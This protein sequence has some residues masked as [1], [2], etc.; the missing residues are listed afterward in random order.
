VATWW[1]LKILTS[2]SIR[3]CSSTAS[4][5]ASKGEWTLRVC[6][7]PSVG[8]AANA[9]AQATAS[10]ASVF[11][12]LRDRRCDAERCA[13]ISRASKPAATSAIATCH[14]KMQTLQHR[15]VEG[16]VYLANRLLLRS[17]RRCLG[18]LRERFRFPLDDDAVMRAADELARG[19]DYTYVAEK[20]D[21]PRKTECER[22]RLLCQPPVTPQE[23]TSTARRA[24]GLGVVNVGGVGVVHSAV[25]QPGVQ[26]AFNLTPPRVA[27]RRR[28]RC[29]S[30]CC[31][32]LRRRRKRFCWR[33]DN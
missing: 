31:V 29:G 10:T 30:G 28:A 12:N 1:S 5:L 23:D 17:R 32:R 15:P 6:T 4:S 9:R 24:N 2:A 25:A 13:G 22:N 16:Y 3:R 11:L 21:S 8:S 18:M 7:G 14:P 26:G 20:H 19:A 33:V 27:D